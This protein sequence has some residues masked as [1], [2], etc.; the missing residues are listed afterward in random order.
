[1]TAFK[2]IRARA[3]K[4]KGGPKALAKL[5]PAKPDPKALARLGDDRI[6]AEMTKRVFCAGF[7]WSVIENKWPGFEKAFL[8]FKP[9]PLSLKPDEFWDDLMKDTRI[10]RNGAK[11]QATIA[12]ARFVVDTAKEH[13]SFSKFLKSWPSMDQIGLVEHFKKHASHLGPTGAMYFLRFN[14]WDAFILSQDVVKALI[15]EKVVTK[16][17]TSKADM[18]AVQAAFNAWTEQ[19]GLPQ[20]D[21]SRILTFSV[22]PSH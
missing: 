17:P 7:A 13:G 15:R 19:S 10:V 9:G 2:T 22:G 4:R 8:G 1:M 5:L 20:R 11:I 12:N 3:E 16:A 6:L 18:K 21:V 14:G